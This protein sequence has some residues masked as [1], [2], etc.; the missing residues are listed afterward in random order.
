MI[1]VGFR[2]TGAGDEVGLRQPLGDTETW[3]PVW[4]AQRNPEQWAE[5]EPA[6]QA[7]SKPK[8]KKAKK[9]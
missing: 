1:V 5:I 3:K 7:W 8:A 9:K 4:E 6:Y 2:K